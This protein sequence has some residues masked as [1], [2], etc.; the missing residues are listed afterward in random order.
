MKFVC[1]TCESYMTFEKAEQ[2][3]EG[4]LGVF[5]G[6]AGCGA[7]ISMVTNAGETQLVSSLGV[8]LG[9]RETPAAPMEATRDALRDEPA[10]ELLPWAADAQQRLDN[11]PEFVRPFARREIERLARGQGH[12]EVTGAVV[13]QARDKFM[14]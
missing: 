3:G 13:D 2:P 10:A 5:F 14:G 4:T 11:I 8:Q 7:R 1:L 9:G 12:T 6:C